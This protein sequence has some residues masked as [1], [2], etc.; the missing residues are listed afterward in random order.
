MRAERLART[1]LDAVT[2]SR[3]IEASHEY[4]Q[5]ADRLEQRESSDQATTMWMPH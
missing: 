1:I 4:R 2:V 3:L 5:E